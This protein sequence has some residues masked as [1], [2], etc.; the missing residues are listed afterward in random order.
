[1]SFPCVSYYILV[2][3]FWKIWDSVPFMAF[4]C[5]NPLR[6]VSNQEINGFSSWI[7]IELTFI[8]KLIYKK[9][10]SCYNVE[11]MLSNKDL[12]RNIIRFN[13]C[14]ITTIRLFLQ[15]IEKQASPDFLPRKIKIAKEWEITKPVIIC[16]MLNVRSWK[17]NTATSYFQ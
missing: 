12:R 6:E 8:A 17:S 7:H 10:T 5:I 14:Q 15:L 2:Y 16:S 1:M 3:T 4:L 11:I 9:E 13:K